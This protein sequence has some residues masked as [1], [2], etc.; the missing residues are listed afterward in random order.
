MTGGSALPAHL[1]SSRLL[2]VDRYAGIRETL[3]PL[4]ERN[5][6]AAPAGF[7]PTNAR[8]KI[9]CLTTWRKGNEKCRLHRAVSNLQIRN[10]DYCLAVDS[11][12]SFCNEVSTRP[13]RTYG[14]HSDFRFHIGPILITLCYFLWQGDVNQ[15]PKQS[16]MPFAMCCTV[17][18]VDLAR[19]EV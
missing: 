19:C 3:A 9:S 1:I 13:F 12:Y 14:I 8:I 4:V 16:A 11:V 7:E 5:R 6:L 17:V 10:S 18:E 2:T 15:L